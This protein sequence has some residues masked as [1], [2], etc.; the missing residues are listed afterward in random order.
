MPRSSATGHALLSLIA[1]RPRWSTYELAGQ[2]TR[3][4]RF[5]LPR[6]ESRIYDEARALAHRGLVRGEDEANGQ[7]PRTVYSI[8]AEGRAEL[9]RWLS[10]PVAATRLQ[11]DG[12]LRVLIGRLATTEHL[13]AAVHQ[14]R[15]DADE[16]F[17]QGRAVADEYLGGTAPFQD[18]VAYRSLV[19]DFLYHH[20]LM[21][22]AWADRAEAVVVA[23]GSPADQQASDEALARIRALVADLPPA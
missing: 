7:R 23:W 9:Q 20:A 18:D 2:V 15:A 10:G 16:I 3:A 14:I 19:F 4:L 21:L 6:A 22:R 5:L 1:L 8:T 13:L 11:S 12:L 17:A